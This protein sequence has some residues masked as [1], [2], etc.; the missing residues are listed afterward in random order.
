[1]V[2]AGLSDADYEAVLRFA[3]TE[4]W[5]FTSE[6]LFSLLQKSPKPRDAS[7]EQAFFLTSEFQSIQSLFGLEVK[8]EM[9][10]DLVAEGKWDFISSFFGQPTNTQELPELRRRIFIQKYLDQNSPVAA[11]LLLQTDFSYVIKKFDDAKIL[12]LLNLV[13]EK[14]E[15][16]QP[17]CLELIKSPRSDS[18]RRKS[19][20]KLYAFLGE[21]FPA[22]YSHEEV[23]ARFFPQSKLSKKE[24]V[25]KEKSS[26]K[27]SVDGTMYLVKE[28]DS[29]WKIAKAHKVDIDEL[30][31]INHLQSKNL[32]PG[33][34]IILPKKKTKSH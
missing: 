4:K 7:L 19:S 33:K 14:N 30:I 34:K 6:G 27:E 9:L 28:G 25:P 22:N 32:K 17:L 26:R 24:M 16:V 8:K 31:R 2:F 5:P 21:S 1:V 13:P 10:L 12:S 18:V 20:E 11:I 15:Q 3:Y 23:I 29:P